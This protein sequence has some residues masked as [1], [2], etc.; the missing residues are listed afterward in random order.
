MLCFSLTR[1]G[2]L[3]DGNILF[4]GHE[5]QDG[6]DGKTCHEAG[7]AVQKAQSQAISTKHT[8]LHHSDL[9]SD[10]IAETGYNKF[11]ITLDS[12]MRDSFSIG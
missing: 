2:H 7:A 11:V 3:R 6:E 8:H 5:T 4:V 10:Y 12:S 9:C 1:L